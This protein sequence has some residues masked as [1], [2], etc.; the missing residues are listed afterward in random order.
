[1]AT[2][3]RKSDNQIA[4]APASAPELTDEQKQKLELELAVDKNEM[5]VDTQASDEPGKSAESVVLA[6]QE[7]KPDMIEDDSDEPV[8]SN[9]LRRF[10]S[11]Y[12]RRKRWAIP[13]TLLAVV[14][15]LAGVPT[16]RYGLAAY[17]V[18]QPVSVTIT[19][20]VTKKPVTSADIKLDGQT[21]KTDKDGKATIGEVKV[22]DHV[23][24]ISKKYYKDETVTVFVPLTK[25]VNKQVSMVATGRQVPIVVVS[26][27]SGKPLENVTL[28]SS[29]TE[30]KTDKDGKATIVLPADKADLPI[31]LSNGGFNTLEARVMVT[32]QAV[33]ENTFALVPNGK[34]Y[35]LSRQ[36]GKIDVVKTDLDGANRQVIVQGTGKEEDRNTV[37]LASRDWKYLALLSKRDSGLARLYLIDT[38]TD[39][40]SEMD[41]GNA[42]FSLIGWNNHDFVYRVQRNNVKYWEPNYLAFKSYNA[43]KKQLFTIDQTAS[44][45]EGNNTYY[46]QFGNGLLVGGKLAYTVTSEWQ[47]SYYYERNMAGKNHSLRVA[48]IS[49]N[50]KKDVKTW[51]ADQYSAYIQSYLYAPGEVYLSIW[52]NATQKDMYFEYENG[53]VKSADIDSEKFNSPYPTYLESPDGK[54]TFWSEQRDGRA[55]FFVGDLAG[56]N[57]KQVGIIDEGQVYGWYEDGYLLVSKKGSEL[58]IMPVDGGTPF[59]VADY[60]KPQLSYRGYGGGYGGL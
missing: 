1:M 14:A 40:M 12:W 41:S 59:K 50:S 8:Q 13:L 35:F 4:E 56:E 28:E 22:G 39:K 44:Q 43:D 52:S 58:Y 29:G 11:G 6:E 30:V 49:S 5:T 57:G 33:K 36:S 2:A 60:H 16:T 48:A 3:K 20:S 10:L 46:Q 31:K 45:T 15:I 9:K 47:G 17:V 26:K 54:R 34:V 7:T 37:L 23:L 27:L 51:P 18:S 53:E 19:D 55:T 42:T 24:S 32:D 38:S 25:A 21:F